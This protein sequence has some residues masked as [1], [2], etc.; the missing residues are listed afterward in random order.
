[1]QKLYTL[2]FLSI[3][4]NI[5]ASKATVLKDSIGVENNN[6][7]KVVI[8]KIEPKETYYSLGRK[9]NVSPKDIISYNDNRSLTPGITVKVP[10]QQPFNTSSRISPSQNTVTTS[11]THTVKAK[12][13]L[14]QIALKYGTTV[15]EL[16]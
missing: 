3:L 5:S 8:H 16:K 6:G 12:E 2:L 1:M 4:Y 15:A 14:G 13:N 10:T 11:N 9:Y 7:K